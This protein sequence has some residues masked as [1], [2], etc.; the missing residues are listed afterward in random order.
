MENIFK[1][2]L[3]CI[4]GGTT[5]R[6]AGE[7]MKEKRIRHLP[8]IDGSDRIVGM[9]SKTDLT[10]VAKFADFPA[11]LFAT[12]PVQ[13]LNVDSPLSLAALLMIEKKISSVILCDNNNTAVG[14]ITSEDLLFQ[15]AQML[16]EKEKS[17][18]GSWDAAKTLSTAGEFFRKL[19]DIGI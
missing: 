14:I 8:I 9:L 17:G 19:S 18:I 2:N 15:L 1:S 11:E 16:G 7:L 4:K 5:M 6:E 3:I 10:D 12:F 13:T